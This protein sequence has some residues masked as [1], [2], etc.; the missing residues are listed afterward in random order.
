MRAIGIKKSKLPPNVRPTSG[1]VLLALFNILNASGRL[2][3]ANVLDLFAGTGAVSL[4]AL[5]YGARAVTAVESDRGG[6][7]GIARL[8]APH[9]EAARVV[10][11]D[12]RRIVPGLARSVATGGEPYGVIFADPPY[13]M[14][15]GLALPPLIE[16]H[17]AIL[18]KGGV[19]VFERAARE[20]IAEISIAR[21]DRVYGETVLSF[22]WT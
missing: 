21:D 17:I 7:S 20:E 8:F 18:A 13:H 5:K 22:Y 4:A 2:D 3:G 10:C 9:G 1:K 16:R 15:W 19:F 14:G 11:G 12:V 6:A